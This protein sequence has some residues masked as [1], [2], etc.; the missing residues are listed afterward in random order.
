M[1]H[2]SAYQVTRF[3]RAISMQLWDWAVYHPNPVIPR[4][5]NVDVPC[6][7]GSDSCTK[8]CPEELHTAL[9]FSAY[10]GKLVPEGPAMT[11]FGT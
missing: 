7:V 3:S 2:Y 8:V 11:G 9:I 5:R 4:V 1:R 10:R 6:G